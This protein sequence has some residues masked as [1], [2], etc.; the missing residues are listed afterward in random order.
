MSES[1][2]LLQLKMVCEIGMHNCL[3]TPVWIKHC[4]SIFQERINTLCK[5]TGL[6]H[7]WSFIGE[8]E[9]ESLFPLLLMVHVKMLMA[10]FFSHP[11]FC[12]NFLK[13]LVGVEG[14]DSFATSWPPALE[15]W[16]RIT[17]SVQRFLNYRWSVKGIRNNFC[18]NVSVPQV[19]CV[20]IF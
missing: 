19:S 6:H 7:K 3:T 12:K 16:L 2:I 17:D 11:L 18:I 8:Q 1:A 10:V 15:R 20:F 5:N 4:P 9:G 13:R 14:G